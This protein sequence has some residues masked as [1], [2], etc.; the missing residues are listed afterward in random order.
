VSVAAYVH[1]LFLD[2]DF[3]KSEATLLSGIDEKKVGEHKKQP[4]RRARDNSPR[5]ISR[6]PGIDATITSIENQKSPIR[7]PTVSV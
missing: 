7:T 2:L 5:K 6:A 3:L 4:V 1:F